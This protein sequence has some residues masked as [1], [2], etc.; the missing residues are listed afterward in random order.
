MGSLRVC[1]DC[2]TLIPVGTYRGRCLPCRRAHDRD[3][4]SRAARGYGA[5]HQAERAAL[6]RRQAAGEVLHC[7]RCGEPVGTDWHLGH[8]DDRSVTRGPEHPEC[9]LKAAG[10]WTRG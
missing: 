7:W 9:N 10:R 5:K 2:P 8:D 3:R 1:L 4:G 6:L